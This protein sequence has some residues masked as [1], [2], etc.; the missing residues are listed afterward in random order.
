MLL[1]QFV[2]ACL[3]SVLLWYAAFQANPEIKP[4]SNVY[5]ADSGRNPFQASHALAP[6]KADWLPV[7]IVLA[8]LVVAAATVPWLLHPQPRNWITW[9]ESRVNSEA[10]RAWTDEAAAYLGP[11]YRVGAGLLTS[12]SEVT[13]VYRH[14]GIPLHDTLTGDNGLL[15]LAAVQRPEMWLR[16]DWAVLPVGDP[17]WKAIQPMSRA[18]THYT[19]EKTIP[20][21]GAPSMQIFRR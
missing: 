10:R 7:I 20:V 19:L 17:M 11:R 12:F 18:G 14:L 6:L 21:T 3:G 9:E 2:V 8:A 13:V 15:W 16:Q 1:V 4:E 5:F